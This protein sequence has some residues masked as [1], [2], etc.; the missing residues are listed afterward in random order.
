[1][2]KKHFAMLLVMAL[3]TFTLPVAGQGGDPNYKPKRLNK[4][5]ELLEAG[6]PVYDISVEGVGYD[7][8]KKLAKDRYDLIQY[9]MEHGA[10]DLGIP[11]LAVHQIVLPKSLDRR[12][13]EVLLLH[14]GRRLRHTAQIHPAPIVVR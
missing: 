7:E 11:R 8:G 3:T 1:M 14:Q 12:H 6:Q 13:A 10:F 4:M 9:Q 5:I 2:T